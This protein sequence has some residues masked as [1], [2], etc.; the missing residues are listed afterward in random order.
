M[1]RFNY[2]F[3]QYV[4]KSASPSERMELQDLLRGE[5]YDE[6][7]KSLI[8]GYFS[9]FEPSKDHPVIEGATEVWDAIHAFQKDHVIETREPIIKKLWP[10]LTAVASIAIAIALGIWFYTS[11]QPIINPQSQALNK[12]KIIPGT[13]KATLTLAN[14]KTISLSDAKT[15]IVID[16]SKVTYNDGAEIKN[17]EV[18]GMQTLST[19]RGGTYQVILPDG[20]QV[21]LNAASTLSFPANFG[22]DNRKVEL[23]GEAYFEVHKDKNRPFIVK[24]NKQQVTVLGTHFNINTYPDE[25]ST[26][27]TLLEGSIKLA[28][29]GIF[30]DEVILKPNQQSILKNNTITV[31]PVDSESAIDW[32]NGYFSFNKEN[33]PAIMRK[34]SRWYDLEIVYYGNY[35]G[36]D[37]TGVVSRKK[38]VSEVLNLLELTGLVHFK[39]EGRRITVM[40]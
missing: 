31:L 16:A 40:P 14:G 22:R 5:E 7:L 12:S 24:S 27:T 13:N 11:N 1:D 28:A 4:S 32:K 34:I 19:P 30:A 18:L 6:R 20:T 25:E 35:T 26:K 29:S 37:F 36:N 8:D 3:N 21:W 10:I 15:G 23:E 33:L 17:A 39:I 2:L 38:E 9:D